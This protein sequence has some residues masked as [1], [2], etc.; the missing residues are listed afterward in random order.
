MSSKWRA[1]GSPDYLTGLMLQ[2]LPQILSV[3]EAFLFIQVLYHT[4]LKKFLLLHWRNL[5]EVAVT[6][7]NQVQF[8][9]I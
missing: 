6:S 9:V 7:R 5:L 4:G 1:D 3:R 8:Q 2:E